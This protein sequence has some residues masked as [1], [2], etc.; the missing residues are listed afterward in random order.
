M[1]PFILPQ[2][3]WVMGV[4]TADVRDDAA[5]DACSLES[6][7]LTHY[8]FQVMQR[9]PC[10]AFHV[11]SSNVQTLSDTAAPIKLP[12]LVWEER[13]FTQGGGKFLLHSPASLLGKEEDVHQ[14][15][16]TPNCYS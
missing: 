3:E 12:A 16:E 14:L 4:K 1:A 6:S 10:L 2:L 9:G 13:C 8:C 15:A 7:W 11:N 5:L